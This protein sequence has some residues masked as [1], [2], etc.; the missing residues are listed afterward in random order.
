MLV[1]AGDRVVVAGGMESMSKAPYLLQRALG[2]RLGDG[3][4]LDAM[5]QDGLRNPFAAADVPG[6]DRCRREEITREELDRWAL[7]SHERA[8]AAAEAGRFAD[9]IVPVEVKVKGRHRHRPRRVAARRYLAGADGEAARPD[10]QDG[11][12][13][14]G[15]APGV[16]DGAGAMVVAPES[17]ARARHETLATII[18]H[19][20]GLGRSPT[21]PTPRRWRRSGRSTR[22]G[23]RERHR[24]LRDQRS[25]RQRR[26]HLRRACSAIDDDRVNVNGGA[27][28]LGHPIGAS[29]ARLVATLAYELRRR[30]GGLGLAAICS[31]GA[32][33]DAIIVHV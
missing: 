12:V 30:G 20:R 22:P 24:P 29:G 17:W 21:W 4:A 7:R 14:A 33:G 2:F 32:Q 19:A 10:R 25:L 1:R 31:G 9:E 28:A 27:I 18:A 6:G 15:N 16:N 11:T 26:D 5:V 13:T 23:C 8:V 3:S